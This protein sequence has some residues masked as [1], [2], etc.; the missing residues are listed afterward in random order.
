MIYVL[1]GVAVFIALVWAGRRARPLLIKREMR[2]VS[3]VLGLTAIAAGAF[4]GL[5]GA[6]IPGALV[7]AIGLALAFSGRTGFVKDAPRASSSE[8]PAIAE[9]RDILGVGP[10]ATAAEIQAAYARLIRAVH[11]DAGGS[12]GLAARLNA[13]RDTLLKR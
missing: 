4:A 10:A 9:A 12:T 8:D 13:A 7:S 3:A 6:W 2:I 5:R 1:I 11:P